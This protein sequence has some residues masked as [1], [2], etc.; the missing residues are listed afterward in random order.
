MIYL[1]RFRTLARGVP[2]P[3]S[4]TV[5]E[6]IVTCRP[7]RRWTEATASTLPNDGSEVFNRS[8][9]G[10]NFQASVISVQRNDEGASLEKQV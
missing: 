5:R 6:F 10:V 4:A 7:R 1:S 9:Q 3:R 2:A 8:P